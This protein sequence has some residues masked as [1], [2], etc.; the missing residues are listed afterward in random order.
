MEPARAASEHQAA[1]DPVALMPPTASHRE[2]RQH[3]HHPH[4]EDELEQVG[5]QDA[6]QSRDVCR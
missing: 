1:C 5:D 3:N 4:L 2:Y 6:P